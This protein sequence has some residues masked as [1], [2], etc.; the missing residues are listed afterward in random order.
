MNGQV[1]A[2]S[3]E[4]R[5]L[6][7]MMFNISRNLAGLQQVVFSRGRYAPPVR[8]PAA[9]TEV[10]HHYH[11]Y[12]HHQEAAPEEEGGGEEPPV[13][14]EGPPAPMEGPPAPMEGPPP[15]ME[16]AAPVEKS[17]TDFNGDY[18]DSY[19]STP[20]V[21]SQ[22]GCDITARWGSAMTVFGR[23]QGDTIRL[24]YEGWGNPIGKITKG[25]VTWQTAN[26]WTW[27]KESAAQDA[28]EEAA[29]GEPPAPQAPAKP[30]NLRSLS[31]KLRHLE[32]KISDM[33]QESSSL[34]AKEGRNTAT[35]RPAQASVVDADDD[36]LPK[37]PAEDAA[38]DAAAAAQSQLAQEGEAPAALPPV[39]TAPAAEG[40]PPAAPLPAAPPPNSAALAAE[41]A[42]AEDGAEDAAGDA[43]DAAD[44]DAAAEAA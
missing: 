10:H 9:K 28:M 12:H 19:D 3:D 13:E 21:V 2:L 26:Y 8:A 42:R 32:K 40:E 27:T 20:V 5:S 15:P 33:G 36:V 29:Q 4:I 37:A 24:D 34:I 6:K 35:R 44:A 25:L 7:R 11:H 30:C 31:N 23:I 18:V 1:L 22:T 41:E 16:A 43:A 38:E 39:S 14:A 17:C